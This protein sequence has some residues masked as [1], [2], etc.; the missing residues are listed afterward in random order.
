MVANTEMKNYLVSDALWY[1]FP[2]VGEPLI[3]IDVF[4]SFVLLIITS[5][6]QFHDIDATT[7][8]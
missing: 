7:Y 8:I 3:F 6:K 4:M 1:M 2:E 5:I